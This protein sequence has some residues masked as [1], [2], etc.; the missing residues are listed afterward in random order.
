MISA[1][2]N[3]ARPSVKVAKKIGKVL[4]FDWKF[5]FLDD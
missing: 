5:F 1:I 3:G 2:E 4:G